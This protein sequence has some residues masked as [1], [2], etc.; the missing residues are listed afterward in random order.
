MTMHS[1][2]GGSVSFRVLI[3]VGGGRNTKRDLLELII[4]AEQI[5]ELTRIL[6]DHNAGIVGDSDPMPS[7]PCHVG[8]C[9]N[10]VSS[11]A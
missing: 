5:G 4:S 8:F 6:A 11:A 10:A 2:L 7:F 9:R 3:G 1:D